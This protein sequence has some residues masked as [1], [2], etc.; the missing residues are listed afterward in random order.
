MK[1]I[2]DADDFCEGND[3]LAV[4][5]LIHERNPAFKI[6]LFAVTGRLPL[7]L[8]YEVRK[9][10]WIQLAHHGWRH[11]TPRE[12]EQWDYATATRYFDRGLFLGLCGG[13]KAPGWQISDGTYRALLERGW[14]VA[15]RAYND[16]RRPEGLRAYVLDHEESGV[17][18]LHYH[19]GHMGGHN[20]NEIGGFADYLAEF[21]GEFLF[22]EDWINRGE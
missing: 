11:D 10:E 5:D 7:W 14:W 16:H 19:I 4:L 17:T 6:T 2:V 9:R 21:E 18:K 15:D 22:V 1:Y 20:A 8:L 3:G 12:C 13:F